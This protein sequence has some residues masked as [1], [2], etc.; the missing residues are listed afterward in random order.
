MPRKFFRKYLPSREWIRGHPHIARFDRWLHHHNLWH[1]NRHSVAGGVAAGLFSGLVP[2][3][4]LVKLPVA[5]LLAIAFR[6]NLPVATIVTLYNNPFTGVPLVILA[7]H[8]GRLFVSGDAAPLTPAPEFDWA[9]SGAWLSATFDWVLSLGK[10]LAAG[11][12]AL[13]LTLAAAG[14]AAVQIGWRAYVIVRWRRRKA[15]RDV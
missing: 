14:Y 6:V 4:H 11:L 12:L 13:A 5:A 3:T 15:T 9:H 1:L 7:Y 10:P 8:V 2:G